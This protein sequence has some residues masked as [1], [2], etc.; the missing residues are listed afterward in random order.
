VCVSVSTMACFG[1]TRFP[2]RC[3]QIETPDPGTVTRRVSVWAIRSHGAYRPCMTKIGLCDLLARL[4]TKA[5]KFV[6]HGKLM[7]G[8]VKLFCLLF[9]YDV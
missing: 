2:N 5:Y 3:S 9:H 6:S 8:L 7:V 1:V 4:T